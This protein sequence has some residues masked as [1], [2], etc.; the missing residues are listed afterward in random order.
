MWMATAILA[1]PDMGN[2]YQ[3]LEKSLA[4]NISGYRVSIDKNRIH[5]K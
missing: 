1:F 5:T 4:V 3:F 2:H